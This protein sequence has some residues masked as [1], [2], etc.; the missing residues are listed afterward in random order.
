MHVVHWHSECI[1]ISLLTTTRHCNW[2]QFNWVKE[3]DNKVSVQWGLTVFGEVSCHNK[4][5]M[6][7][8]TLK[9]HGKTHKHTLVSLALMDVNFFFYISKQLRKISMWWFGRKEKFRWKWKK[10]L[11]SRRLN[12]TWIFIGQGSCKN[13]SC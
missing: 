13:K 5:E 7:T 2:P 8:A 3:I 9:R 10:D 11:A 6:C 1:A 12:M 4:L